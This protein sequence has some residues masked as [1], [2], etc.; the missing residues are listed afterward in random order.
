M[1]ESQFADPIVRRITSFLISIGLGVRAGDV[2][3]VT[4]VP[5]IHIDKGELIVDES[6]L[7]YPGDLLHEAGHVVVRPKERWADITGGVDSDAGEEMAAIAWSYAAAVHLEIDPSIVFHSGGYKD[8]SQA[9]LSSFAEG[10]GIG[11]PML[12]YFGMSAEVRQ[13]A[14]LGRRPFPA[15]TRW[16]R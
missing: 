13:A 6:R 12:Q 16:T 2:P 5:G 3:A 9:I 4:V 11:V 7:T 8:A 14:G 10:G 15:M 1:S